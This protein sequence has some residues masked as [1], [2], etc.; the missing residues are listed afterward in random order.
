MALSRVTTWTSGQVLTASALNGEFDNILNNPMS[1]ISPLASNLNLNATTL[2]NLALGSV[3]SPSLYFSG[4]SNTGLYSSG[5]DTVDIAAGGIRAMSF[6]TASSGV[7]YLTSTP[8]ATTA[9]PV[10]AAAGSDTDI[11]I[12]VEGKGLGGVLMNANS[13]TPRA[14]VAYRAAITRAWAKVTVSAGTP[15]I[16][17]SYNLTSIT[18]AGVGLLTVTW[19]RDFASANYVVVATCENDGVANSFA[20]ISNGAFAAGALTNLASI[21]TAAAARDPASYSIIAIGAQ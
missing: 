16:A 2:Q 15:A 10:I 4:D 6:A 5:A 13:G 9:M 19:D 12:K 14:N 17:A 20:A 18:D 11:D 3:S 21:D 8:A 1:L 7:N